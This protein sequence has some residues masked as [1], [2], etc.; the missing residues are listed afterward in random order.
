MGLDMYL[1]KKTY[2]QNWEHQIPEEKHEVIVK[3]GGKVV[4]TIKPHR[5]KYIVEEAGYWRKANHI[6]KWFV[7]NVQDGEDNCGEYYVEVSDLI[8]LL[9]VC[10]QVKETPSKADELLPTTEGFFFGGTDYDEYYM[11]DIEYTIEILEQVLLEKI[12]NEKGREYYPADFY[13][14]SSW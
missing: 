5:V 6:H 14:T 4:E 9:N 7:D 1:S 13:Y 2:V 12:V 11:R 8:N 3:R 10:K